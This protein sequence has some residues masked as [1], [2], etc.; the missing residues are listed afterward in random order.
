MSNFAFLL[1]D[2]P[3]LHQEALLAE[4][5]ALSDSK[6]C[7]LYARR[8]LEATVKWLYANDP[9]FG[10]PYDTSLNALMSSSDFEACVPN[11]VRLL[12]HSLRKV[13]NASVHELRAV[14]QTEAL[15]A[16]RDLF[17]V[18][19]WF[20]ATYR[21][22]NTQALPK[23]FDESLLPVPATVAVAK[24]LAEVK[25]LEETLKKQTEVLETQ[26]LEGENAKAELEALRLQVAARKAAN[27]KAPVPLVFS[28]EETRYRLID[29]MLREVGWNPQGLNV[30]EY[31]TDAGRADYVL[32]GADGV[33]L[34]VVEVKKTSRDARGWAEAS[35]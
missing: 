24:S 35:T 10:R 33:P 15:G 1:P 18:L 2:F 20:V 23:L 6:V 17:G 4:T 25:A 28:E 14:K 31:K 29:V 27:V 21:T 26:R 34:A 3:A 11:G 9:A 12:G 30:R 7:C 8:T 13:S 22:R 5:N 19:H 32:W 16:L